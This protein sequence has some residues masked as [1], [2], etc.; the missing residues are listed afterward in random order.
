M[1]IKLQQMDVLKGQIQSLNNKSQLD[2]E[3]YNEKQKSLKIKIQALEHQNDSKSSTIN[4]LKT[5]E[6][7]LKQPD[8]K[9]LQNQGTAHLSFKQQ[10]PIVHFKDDTFE[11][12]RKFKTIIL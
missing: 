4:M 11:P 2:K 12:K 6:R 10:K 7:D 1:N 8:A 5:V 9:N 3:D